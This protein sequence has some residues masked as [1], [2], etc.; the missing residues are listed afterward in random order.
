[1]RTYKTWPLAAV[2]VALLASGFFALAFVIERQ[3]PVPGEL[4][5]DIANVHRLA[6]GFREI[7]IVRRVFVECTDVQNLVAERSKNI[8]DRIFQREP[9]MIRTN[10]KFHSALTFPALL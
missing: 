10:H 1:M 5:E 3:P 9:R 2:M 8:A 7:G 6:N 4:P